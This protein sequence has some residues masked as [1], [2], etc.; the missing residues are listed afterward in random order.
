MKLEVISEPEQRAWPTIP[1][2][3][4]DSTSQKIIKTDFY[5]SPQAVAGP[6]ILHLNDASFYKTTFD[7]CSSVHE[8]IDSVVTAK[9]TQIPTKSE[10]EFIEPTKVFELKQRKTSLQAA[11]SVYT[12]GQGI[13]LN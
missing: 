7:F 11:M 1:H 12:K 5:I 10:C 4:L 8:Q 3:S 2:P 6:A 13:L 9:L